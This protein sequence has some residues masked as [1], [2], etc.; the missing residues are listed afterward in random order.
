[1]H[2]VGELERDVVMRARGS[3]TNSPVVIRIKRM[4]TK[5]RRIQSDIPNQAGAVEIED[6]LQ[7]GGKIGEMAE[8]GGPRRPWAASR[9]R[10]AS[11]PVKQLDLRALG[12]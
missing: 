6:L 10:A 9:C 11:K 4:K 5:Y 8:I 2:A 1:V 12:H 3:R 7:V